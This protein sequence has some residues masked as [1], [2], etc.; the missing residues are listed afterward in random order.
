MSESF[1]SFRGILYIHP[2]SHCPI[3]NPPDK[4]G[5][6]YWLMY[7]VN[8][9]SG[10]NRLYDDY[11]PVYAFKGCEFTNC[12]PAF[13]SNGDKVKIWGRIQMTDKQ[14]LVLHARRVTLM[15]KNMERRKT[16]YS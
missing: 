10:G 9:A 11:I 13:L 14:V 15:K 7:C 8:Y 1:L 12:N 16:N 3:Q 5:N 2:T 6:A 4:N